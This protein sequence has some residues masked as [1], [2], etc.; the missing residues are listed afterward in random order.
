[1]PSDKKLEKEAKKES[2]DAEMIRELIE[3]LREMPN[4]SETSI[5]QIVERC[6]Y[7]ANELERNGEFFT[8]FY[9]VCKAAKKEHI[10]LHWPDYGGIPLG[11]P[12]NLPFILRN[13]KGQI[14]CPR[15][16]SI[17]TA[18]ILYGYPLMDEKLKAKI[19]SGKVRLGG[20]EIWDFN[21]DRYCN[22]CKKG[23]GA[24][25]YIIGENGYEL[26][27]DIVNEVTF[28]RFC[29]LN[30]NKSVEINIK[31]SENGADVKVSK[32]NL[33]NDSEY[34]ISAKKWDNFLYVLYHDLYLNDWKHRF[35]NNNILDGERWK[36]TVIMKD[37]RK[38]TYS[39]SNGYPP[40]WNGFEKLMNSF[41]KK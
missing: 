21:D 35:N 5:R 8:I 10:A 1:M 17:N 34:K 12:Y 29:S 16:G 4:G 31:K 15:C 25:A 23:F 3:E 37:G 27:R 24:E 22:N 30:M 36:L 26:L 11:L 18:R 7:D 39:G 38:Q 28:S 2:I 14:K 13:D 41:V 32:L 19:E 20:C 40:Y 33:S 9:K 6:G